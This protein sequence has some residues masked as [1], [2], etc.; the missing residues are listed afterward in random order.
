MYFTPVIL[1][2]AGFQNKQQ[3]LL[4]SCLPAAVN[5]AGT[6]VGADAARV[7]VVFPS[8][9]VCMDSSNSRYIVAAAAHVHASISSPEDLC[10]KTSNLTVVHAGMQLIERSGR[11]SLLLSSLVGVVVSLVALSIP[12]ATQD[13]LPVSFTEVPDNASTC[14]SADVQSCHGCLDVQ[15]VFCTGSGADGV[16]AIW[17]L[18]STSAGTCE[19]HGISAYS[20]ACPNSHSGTLLVCLM[21]YLLAFAVGMG[22][23]PWVYNSE[24]YPV[25][26]RGLASGLAGTANWVT[27]AIVSQSFLS[28]TQNLTTAGTFLVFAGLAAIGAVWACLFVPE[29][30][31]LSLAEIQ[32]L[33]HRRAGNDI[34]RGLT[35]NAYHVSM[36]RVSGGQPMGDGFVPDADENEC[37]QEAQYEVC[38]T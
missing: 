14:T 23:L 28:L 22:P 27:N 36:P 13:S 29:T 24:M 15:C 11:R 21:I 12:F 18:D 34:P 30:K 9:F 35:C 10:A 2:M 16:R 5:A 4:L 26:V 25:D 6:I 7:L 32:V 19:D 1:Q 33:F 37:S 38:E 3:A 17:C 31:G 20:E 8:N